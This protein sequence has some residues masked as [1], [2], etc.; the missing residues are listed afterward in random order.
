V[1]AI[2][3]VSVVVAAAAATTT[4]NAAAATLRTPGWLE[5]RRA[6]VIGQ[7][8]IRALFF[9]P[10]GLLHKQGPRRARLRGAPLPHSHNALVATSCSVCPPAGGPSGEPGDSPQHQGPTSVQ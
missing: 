5:Q 10:G 8:K 9:F 6:A 1:P 7:R 4:A 3:T 2:V